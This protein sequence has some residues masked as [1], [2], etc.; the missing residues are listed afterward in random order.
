MY[1]MD[2]AVLGHSVGEPFR[3]P[4]FAIYNRANA[5]GPNWQLVVDWISSAVDTNGSPV[6]SASDKL[7]IRNVF[8]I[9]ANDCLNAS[10]TGGDHPEPIGTTNSLSLLPG[11]SAYRMAANNYYLGHARLL[12]MMALCLD[13]ADDPPINAALTNSLGNTLDSY[14]SDAAGAWLYQQYAMY[15]E[16]ADVISAYGLSPNAKV[17]LASGGLPPEGFLYGHSYGFLLGGLLALQ[18][19]GCNSPA[20]CGPQINLI[21]APMWDRFVNGFIGSLTPDMKTSASAPWLQPFYQMDSYGD[22]LRLYVTPDFVQPLALLGLLDQQR[23]VSSRLNAERWFVTDALEGGAGN[24]LQR[25]S[26]P[27]TWGDVGAILYFLLLDPS[28]PPVTDPRPAFPLAFY[29]PPTGRLIDRTDWTT[30]ANTFDFRCSW[31][32]INHQNSDGG[33]FEFYRKREWLT[34]EISNYDNNNEGETCDY[35]NTLSLHNT[36]PAGTPQNLNWF[37]GPAWTNG[38]QWALGLNAGDPTAMA[39]YTNTYSFAYGDMTPLYNRPSQWTPTNAAMNVLHASRSILWLKPDHIVVYDRAMTQTN[40]LFKRFNLSLVATPTIQGNLVTE[41]T[42]G[43]QSLFVTTLLPTN[44]TFSVYQIGTSLNPIADQEPSTCRLVI[45]DTSRPIS[46]R[47]L[48]VLQGADAGIA[49]DVAT[50]V[51]SVS[52]TAFEGAGVA[53]NLV[54]FPVTVA[55]NIAGVAYLVSPAFT[56]HFV[57]GLT[58]GAGYAVAV[59][60]SAGMVQITVSAGGDRPVCG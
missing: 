17:G 45:E 39:S 5:T 7:T 30:N 18:T 49:A 24:L 8:L 19:A 34:K 52:G 2:Q 16:K 41:T 59:G 60:S 57:T 27:Q 50:H 28:A 31:R 48:H 46:A 35:H 9:W 29:D 37:E 56:N 6:L 13:A 1:A 54:L 23:G 11:G 43:G 33:Q 25:I 40:G 42:P 58:P 21:S 47:F 14:L 55:S 38:S 15:G 22:L 12:T 4:A 3:H 32:S 53:G 51:Q 44:A 10:T 26:N 20:L 36:C